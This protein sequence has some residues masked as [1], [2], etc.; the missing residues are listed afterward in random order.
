MIRS[1]KQAWLAAELRTREVTT[2]TESSVWKRFGNAGTFENLRTLAAFLGDEASRRALIDLGALAPV[3]EDF[4]RDPACEVNP[5]RLK[6][7]PEHFE[8]ML[9]VRALAAWGSEP[10]VR[11]ALACAVVEDRHLHIT[12]EP[13][14]AVRARAVAAASAVLREPSRDNLQRAEEAAQACRDLYTPHEDDPGSSVAV[15]LWHELGAAW[16]AAEAAAANY[17]LR[18]YDGPG[19]TAASSTWGNRNSVWPQRAAAAAAKACGYAVV[20][21]SIRSELIAWVRSRP[22]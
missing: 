3:M 4:R 17:A 7:P 10:L 9:L 16:F 12:D 2:M 6:L 20:C 14:L 11:A 19:P 18:D 13:L 21:D 15:T 1:L 5:H 22:L 8:A